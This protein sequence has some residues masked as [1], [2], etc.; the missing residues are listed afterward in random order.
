MTTSWQ[1]AA[2]KKREEIYALL[3]EEWRVDNLPSVK[4]QVDV[5]DYIKKHLSE[6]EL[7][8]TESDAEQI[9]EK[10]TSG[11][12]TAEKVARAFCHRAAL[13][14]QLVSTIIPNA[15]AGRIT[16]KLSSTACMRSSSTQLLPMQSSSMHTL[17]NTKSPLVLC[18]VFLSR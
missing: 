18:T 6:E 13:A 10:T 17:Q 12:W 11:S 1:D 3:P 5:T 14:H 15:Q 9:V 7:S 2:A 16:N 4:E 8:I